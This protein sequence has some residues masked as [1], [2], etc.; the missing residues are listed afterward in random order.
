MVPEVSRR[1]RDRLWP[2]HDARALEV[3]I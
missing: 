2:R 3:T 1:P